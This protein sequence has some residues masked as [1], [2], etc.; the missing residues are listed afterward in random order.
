LITGKNQKDFKKKMKVKCLFCGSIF[1]W[2][3]I[4]W[5]KTNIY[6]LMKII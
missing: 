3:W 4:S 5:F 2:K 1:C 6:T